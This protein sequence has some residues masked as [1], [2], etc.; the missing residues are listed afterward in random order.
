MTFDQQQ[1][2]LIS[3]IVRQVGLKVATPFW[4]IK[5]KKKRIVGGLNKMEIKDQVEWKQ[6][7]FKAY[8]ICQHILTSS[9]IP[10]IKRAKR[11]LVH[12]TKVGDK[13]KIIS[14]KRDLI[15]FGVGYENV[16][17]IAEAGLEVFDTTYDQYASIP[18]P[19]FDLP[20]ADDEGGM[21]WLPTP[22]PVLE[23]QTKTSHHVADQMDQAAIEAGGHSGVPSFE[24]IMKEDEDELDI[25]VPDT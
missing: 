16:R 12:A 8:Q 3:S 2:A 18:I 11:L 5:D 23:K 21:S 7:A 19:G 14:L 13:K 20:T 22:E 9:K 4:I 17:L 1:A 10:K 6:R 24:E 15:E 25:Q